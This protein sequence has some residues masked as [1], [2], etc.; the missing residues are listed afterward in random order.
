MSWQSQSHLE[1]VELVVLLLALGLEFP[2]SECSA[3]SGLRLVASLL[4]LG[5]PNLPRWVLTAEPTTSQNWRP[6]QPRGL[7]GLWGGGFPTSFQPIPLGH[8]SP[9]SSCSTCFSCSILCRGDSVPLGEIV[10]NNS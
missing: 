6:S 8:S 10:S 1:F 9:G 3:W 2:E 4:N 5:A 7:S